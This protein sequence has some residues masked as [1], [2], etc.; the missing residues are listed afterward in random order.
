LEEHD[1]AAV[2]GTERDVVP[3]ELGIAGALALDDVAHAPLDVG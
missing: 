1:V 2:E 3:I